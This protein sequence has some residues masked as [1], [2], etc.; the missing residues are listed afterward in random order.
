MDDTRE[1]LHHFHPLV[2][3]WFSS[4]YGKPTDPQERAWP[5]IASGRNVL[6]TAPTGTGKTYAA[7]LFALNE[8]IEGR[9]PGG[10]TRV[11]YVSP[12]KALNTD[13]RQ[14]LLAPLSELAAFFREKGKELPQIAVAT[15]SG[16][17]P[18]SER[19]RM[20]RRPPE[21]LITTPE[22]LN[23]ILASPRSRE[24]LAGLK[25]VILDEVHAIVGTKRGTHLITAVERLVPVAG[26]LQRIALSAT[27]KP[28]EDT[29]AFVGGYAARQ[30]GEEWI[31]EKR[32][33][34]IV[35]SA[36]R[37]E[38]LL[39]VR[40]VGPEEEPREGS[41]HDGETVWERM[42][43]SLSEIIA[44]R[45]STLVFVNS[46]QLAERLAHLLNA[47][48]GEL[49]AYAHHG[50]LSRE[51]R[52][53]VEKRLKEG[54][55]RAIVATS[56][57]E[58][59]IDIGELDE[60]LLVDTPPSISQ[61]VQR[62]GRAGHGV[63]E[64]ARGVLFAS[65]GPNL[66]RGVVAAK[67]AE[68]QNIE[69]VHPIVCPLDV[70][71]QVIVSMVGVEPWKLSDLYA[72]LR[73][74]YPFH[75]L[76]RRQFD[77]VIEMLEGRY[78]DSRVRE[79]KA[80]VSIDRQTDV[81]RGREGVLYLLYSGGGTIP[82]RGYFG[83]HVQ[84]S[85]AKVGELD[86]EFVW[87]RKVGDTFSLGTQ[88]WK[89]T[90][91]DH[92]RVRVVPW[93]GPLN[94]APFWRAEGL[95]RDFHFSEEVA[96]A[97]ERWEGRIGKPGFVEELMRSYRIDEEGASRLEGF[98]RRQAEASGRGLPHR[99]RILVEHTA[100]QGGL[101]Q[102]IIHTIWGGKVN[103]PFSLA[104][105][106][107]LR[108]TWGEHDIVAD[109]DCIAITLAH[110]EAPRDGAELGSSGGFAAAYGGALHD[111]EGP[112][113][114]GVLRE[115]AEADLEEL[116]RQELE[117][118]G[119]F[120]ARFRE[121]A[122]RAL[123][124]PRPRG[125][126]RVPLWVTRLRAKKLLDRVRRYPDFPIVAE[127]WRSC[128]RDEM[129][130]AALEMLLLEIRTG[131]ISIEECHTLAPSPFAAG[132]MW[133]AT[134]GYMY[135]DDTPGGALSGGT[136]LSGELLSDMVFSRELRIAFDPDLIR[137]FQEKLQRS[138][139]GYTPRS[140]GELSDWLKERLVVPLEEWEG[141]LSGMSRDWGLDPARVR[142]EVAP[143]VRESSAGGGLF[144]PVDYAERVERALAGETEALE[145]TLPQWLQFYGPL[146]VSF[147]KRLFGAGERTLEELLDSLE[148]E[149]TIVRDFLIEGLGEI[150]LCDAEN[151]ERLL[152]FRRREETPP[153]VARPLA[154]LPLFLARWQGL[155]GQEGSPDELAGRLEGL[156]GY[157]AQAELW[158]SE[159]LPAR[160]AGYRRHWLDSLL[161]E[162]ELEWFGCGKRRIS[163]RL[164]SDAELY[165]AAA[166]TG[167]DGAADPAEPG[168]AA[169][170]AA[171][172]AVPA[173]PGSAPAG[174]AGKLSALFADPHARYS[175]WDLHARSGLPTDHFAELL[176]QEV[177]RGG[178]LCDSFE[179]VRRGAQSG[180]KV[181]PA[182][183]RALPLAA[184][185]REAAAG[186]GLGA[187]KGGRP[188]RRDF[189][190]WKSTRPLMGTWYLPPERPERDLLDEGE[191]AK[192]RVRLLLERYGILFRELLV[193]ELPS[194]RWPSLFRSMRLMEL[195]GELLSGQFFEGI[196]GLQ[197]ISH[198]AFS[199]LAAGLA[200]ETLFWVNALDPAS[201]CGVDLPTKR[202]L[203]SRLPSNRVVY[204]GTEV[205]VVSRQGGRELE[206][207][208]SPDHPALSSCLAFLPSLLARDADPPKAMKVE[209]INGKP[210][211]TS[212]YRHAL[213]AL[214]FQEDFKAYT[215]WAR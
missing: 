215:L 185:A 78:A 196:P 173:A 22:S 25:T 198:A 200:G 12:L 131:A 58:L 93:S 175:F 56:S 148:E 174:A 133:L 145:K 101:R 166:G 209:S 126:Q 51:L 149:R 3:E 167:A 75:T 35:R 13:V 10:T 214:G 193:R 32:A 23:L 92:Q 210:V 128:I 24:M 9:W 66:V 191:S 160:L 98:L 55:L 156:F 99:H 177:W 111:A 127:T 7:F 144:I 120:G 102:I 142:E 34:E 79:L 208:V 14:N 100:A 192:E 135:A 134:G 205:A 147:V 187:R 152:L 118:S 73:T 18:Q 88:R 63:G 197:F 183:V 19:R 109:N 171:A 140:V 121:N 86:E 137:R 105:S 182:A 90:G 81:V 172:T 21:I 83:L 180:F 116:L 31:Y 112:D 129:D 190:R 70:L 50:S 62:L 41:R 106:A 189:D 26:E 201:L 122:G 64:V 74:S 52:S 49:I 47:G 136:S 107:L 36:V 188:S 44:E 143:R 43:R 46:R 163:F 28:L 178:L 94:A 60:V 96:L 151:L 53:V 169:A 42:S 159:I 207:R 77:L 117:G 85:D 5:L 141:L 68:A 8:L 168:F 1:A 211:R 114:A 91:I 199:L 76:S 158:E 203:P 194:F 155:G 6:I 87:E 59:G 157:P 153:F 54:D 202:E 40:S 119:F 204:R 17:T 71:A 176:W 72:M 48:Q 29:A 206:I 170:A 39:A 124:L 195:A 161:A 125:R 57:L 104:L 179:V 37:K 45:R 162:S 27:V 212:P 84:G 186:G 20:A 67:L 165:V 123:L 97:L 110:E 11:L 38:A 16:D 138:A 164:A 108:R 69:E 146:P 181:D 139:R 33:V 2:R 15:R 82:D 95:N 115:L 89:I 103:H 132:S 113:V 130:L 184:R 213:I 150:A 30:S 65:N 80:R 154:E 61:T 4:R